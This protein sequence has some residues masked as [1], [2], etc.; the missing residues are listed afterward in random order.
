V[1]SKSTL[2]NIEHI[3]YI[4]TSPELIY[5][6]LTTGEGWDAWFTQGTEVDAKSGGY[7]RLRWQ[8]FGAG[9]WATEDGGP[10][11]EAEPN[12]KFVFQW[13]PGSSPTTVSIKLHKLGAGTLLKLVESGYSS[14][15]NDVAAFIGCA[16]GW[17]EAL[18]LLKFY[19]EHG[20]TYGEV[21]FEKETD[22]T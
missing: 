8:N 17:G 4:N 14:S 18:T 22:L 16:T 19:L 21:P 3:T 6:T 2:P 7:I 12:Q 20:V 13:S 9:H 10:V 11:L 1:N 15:E 5:K